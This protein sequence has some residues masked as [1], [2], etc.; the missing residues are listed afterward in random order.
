VG[1]ELVIRLAGKLDIGRARE[2]HGR[3]LAITR[4]TG[5]V[6][7][8]LSAVEWM[9]SSAVQVLV[10]LGTELKNQGRRFHLSGL[11]EPVSNYLGTIGLL[12]HL[13]AGSYDL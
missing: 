3:A 8:D 2:L 11:A 10:A 4:E 7:V 5:D 1:P 6:T 13:A 9:D 12:S